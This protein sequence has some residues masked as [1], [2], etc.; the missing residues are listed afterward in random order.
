MKQKKVEKI[1]DRTVIINT[2]RELL[3]R[4]RKLEEE[5]SMI[6]KEIDKLIEDIPPGNY[7]DV[8]IIEAEALRIDTQKLQTEHPEIYYKYLKKTTYKYAKLK[9]KGGAR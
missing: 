6:K 2:V 1:Q 5:V 9:Q 7:E 4:K 3:I 8:S